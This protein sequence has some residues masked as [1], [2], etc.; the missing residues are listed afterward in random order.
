MKRVI[1]TYIKISLHHNTC[2]TSS[3]KFLATFQLTA[4]WIVLNYFSIWL[5]RR[6]LEKCHMLFL[7]QNGAISCLC[8][9]LKSC[10]L[11][12][13]FSF[14]WILFQYQNFFLQHLPAVQTLNLG[15]NSIKHVPVF[16]FVVSRSLTTLIL[17]NNS[18][19]SL[20]GNFI[21]FWLV[22]WVI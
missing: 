2:I 15:Y 10:D 21:C 22:A 18:L 1:R 11:I 6:I 9:P 19:T 4:M 14:V 7:Y 13:T 12:I 8:A 16:T 20:E 17:C 5:I 3:Q